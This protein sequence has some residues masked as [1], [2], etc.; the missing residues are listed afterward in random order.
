MQP[1]P[2][3]FAPLAGSEVSVPLRMLSSVDDAN[4]ADGRLLGVWEQGL[5][6][7]EVLRGGGFKTE[8][9]HWSRLAAISELCGTI[10][11]VYDVLL[12][13]SGPRA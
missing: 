8:D 2:G 5:A 6:T 1:G 3:T 11:L 7:A 13:L 12:S 4:A 10:T 9:V